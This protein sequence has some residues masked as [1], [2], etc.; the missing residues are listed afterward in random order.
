MYVRQCSGWTLLGCPTGAELFYSLVEERQD[1]INGRAHLPTLKTMIRS[2]MSILD[3]KTY[4]DSTILLGSFFPLASPLLFLLP[5]HSQQESFH[6]QGL[7][8]EFG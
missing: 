4:I 2:D 1:P 8:A 7:D 6:G 3:W 5:S